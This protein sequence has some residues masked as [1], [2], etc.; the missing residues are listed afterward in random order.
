MV[1]HS[2]SCDVERYFSALIILNTWLRNSMMHRRLNV[3]MSRNIHKEKFE[4]LYIDDILKSFIII[5]LRKE[6]LNLV[7]NFCK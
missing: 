7:N 2:R 1:S 4:E 6:V 3:I 5:Y